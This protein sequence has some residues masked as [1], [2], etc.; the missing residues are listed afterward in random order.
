MAETVQKNFRMS[1]RSIDLLDSISSKLG[2]TAT[3]V[4]EICVA[5]HAMALEA[6]I[7]GARELFFEKMTSTVSKSSSDKFSIHLSKEWMRP[8]D[9][10]AEKGN[11]S[12]GKVL[13]NLLSEAQGRRILKTIEQAAIKKDA[14]ISIVDQKA[15][16][17]L[18]SAA[19]KI[20]KRLD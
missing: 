7:D 8:I 16:N 1:K 19:R 3:D 11:S 15:S 17:L 5:K 10:L 4:V 13:E 12:R 18:G 6:D 9:E 2:I 20:Q 14:P